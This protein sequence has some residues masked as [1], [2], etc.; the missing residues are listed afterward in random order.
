MVHDQN[1]KLLLAHES[2][3]CSTGG[4]KQGNDHINELLKYKTITPPWLSNF[5][6]IVFH[7]LQ[8]Q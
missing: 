3:F 6:N 7:P 2:E 8:N 1:S 5:R 4:A